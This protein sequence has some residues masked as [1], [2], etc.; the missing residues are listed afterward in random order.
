MSFEAPLSNW[1]S[2]GGEFLNSAKKL[3]VVDLVDWVQNAMSLEGGCL[4]LNRKGRS[5]MS[6]YPYFVA[7]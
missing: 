5:K 2:I 3:L 1:T 6:T 4:G 7:G